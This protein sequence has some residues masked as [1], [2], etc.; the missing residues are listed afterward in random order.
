MWKVERKQSGPIFPFTSFREA[1]CNTCLK[2][3]LGTL[4]RT[5]VNKKLNGN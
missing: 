2:V 5:G 4:D 3:G 1:W